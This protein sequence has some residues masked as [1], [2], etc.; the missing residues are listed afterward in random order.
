M[1]K[2]RRIKA[3]QDDTPS[4]NLANDLLMSKGPARP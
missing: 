4:R 3:L 2:T 1:F